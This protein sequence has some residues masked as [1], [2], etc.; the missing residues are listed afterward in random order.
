MSVRKLAFG[1]LLVPA[2]AAMLAAQSVAATTPRA[3]VKDTTAKDSV[4]VVAVAPTP[5]PTVPQGAVQSIRPRNQSG[6]SV[7]ETPKDSGK[8]E[9]MQL[10]LGG[11]F[12][13]QF[14]GLGHANTASVR[15]V[16][17]VNQNKL[18]DIGHGFNTAAANLSLQVQLADG[19]RVDLISYLSSRR[20]NE[21]W[22]KGGYLQ[23]DKLAFLKSATIDDLMK[24]LTI[25]AGHFEINY[26]DA[27][28][29]RS[30]NGDALYN[31]FVGNLVLD[32]FTTEIGG[33]VMFRKNGFLA[34]AGATGGEIKGNLRARADR[35]PAFLGKL[36]FDK[37]LTQSLRTR[38]T[39]ST[40]ISRKS[41]AQTLYSG[42]RAGSRYM[43]VLENT[44]ATEPGSAASG[45][46]NPGVRREVTSVMINP[47]IKFNGLELF[48]TIEQSNGRAAGEARDRYVRQYSSE[49]VY[50][51][52]GNEQLYVA[53][54]YNTVRGN[55]AGIAPKV[56]IERTAAALG[57]FMTPNVLVKGELVK[58]LYKDFPLADIRNGGKFNGFMVEGVVAF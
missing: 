37:Q 18:L 39:G 3:A 11:A 47:F 26:G 32:A 53:A 30:D 16:A 51:F 35:A 43:L 41:P 58:Q 13:Q 15:T 9:G 1:A 6:I 4:P 52:A 25:R 14:Q 10:R 45:L 2:L 48:G 20:H 54:R 56:G 28:L 7:F 31:P 55:L 42:D 50:R 8:F 12:V 38:L 44:L 19:I 40:Y 17:G 22:V 24:Y 5:M 27:P 49:A 21:T 23:V 36:G 34:M 57:W 46:F 29:R 33:D